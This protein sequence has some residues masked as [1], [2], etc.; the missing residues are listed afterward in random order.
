MIKI[1]FKIKNII[2]E[3]NEFIINS[4][5]NNKYIGNII[6]GSVDFKVY[7]ENNNEVSISNIIENNIIKIY[8]YEEK[9]NI[10]IKKILITNNYL[11]NS[12]SSEELDY[13]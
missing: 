11:L 9:N 12:D 1:K 5:D 10:I 6:K 13:I 3:N 7:N 4:I 8:G 2:I